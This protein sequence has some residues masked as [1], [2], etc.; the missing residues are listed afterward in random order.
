MQAIVSDIIVSQAAQNGSLL[1]SQTLNNSSSNSV[2][3]ADMLNSINE[4]SEVIQREGRNGEGL[5]P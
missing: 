1:V 2:S 5:H 4:K 3:F